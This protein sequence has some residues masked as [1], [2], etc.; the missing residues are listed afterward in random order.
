[1]GRRRSVLVL[2]CVLFCAG[3]DERSDGVPPGSVEAS[4]APFDDGRGC[5]ID[6]SLP[7]LPSVAGCIT[8]AD[9]D[10][11][12]DGSMET[13]VVYSRVDTDRIP[14]DW[15][16]RV[17]RSDGSVV[18]EIHLGPRADYQ[19]VLGAADI[20]GDGTDEWLVV[21]RNLA[22]HG[23]AWRELSLYVMVAN[24][25]RVVTLEKQ[26]IRL[27]V[28]GVSRTGEGVA[29]RNGRLQ[30]LRAEAQNIRNTRWDTSTRTYSI[31]GARA[32]LLRRETAE[33]SLS[34]YNDPDLDPFFS[35]L[36][37]NVRYTP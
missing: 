19:R 10:A 30:L 24:D 7:S 37:G 32:R 5:P 35:L 3:C 14:R 8:A 23:A 9:G 36:C 18:E 29:C 11:D 2:V 6:D 20:Q 25:L 22:G 34:D 15:F 12:G 27:F 17:E 26:P 31:D 1:M 13:F 33:L 28:G 4:P 16:I 21:T